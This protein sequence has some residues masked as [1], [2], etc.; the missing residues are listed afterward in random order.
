MAK[1]KKKHKKGQSSRSERYNKKIL[2]D[3]LM[4]IFTNN[5][6]KSYNYKQLSKELDVSDNETR[7]LVTTVL[8]ELRGLG[9]L[10]ELY[11]GKY[12]LKSKGGYIIGTDH[13]AGGSG[14]LRL[15][16]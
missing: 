15:R 1:K 9:H 14:M 16:I 4:G 7:K 11:A 5:P 8:H 2:T 6:T 3:R 10:E 13:R 12:K